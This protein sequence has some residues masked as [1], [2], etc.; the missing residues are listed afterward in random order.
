MKKLPAVFANGE[1]PYRFADYVLPAILKSWTYKNQ[2][3]ENLK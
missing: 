2:R 1:M 3:I